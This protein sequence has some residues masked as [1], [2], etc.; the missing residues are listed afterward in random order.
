MKK[1]IILLILLLSTSALFAKNIKA[2]LSYSIFNSPKDGHF[3]ETYL[4]VSSK[5][6][7]FVKNA[8]GKY[9]ATVQV[10]IAF[11]KND[12]IKS[13]SK[14]DLLSPEVSDTIKTDISFLDQQRFL[15]ADG[16]YTLE[17]SIM[18]KNKK[19]ALPFKTTEFLSIYFPTNKVSISGIEF[20][21]SFKKTEI[22]GLLTKSGYDLIP[23]TFNFYPQTINNLT[24]YAEIYNTDKVFAAE[25]KFILNYYI[26]TFETKKMLNDYFKFIKVTSK[27]VIVAFNEFDITN[28]PSGNYNLVVEVRNKDNE[29][30]ANNY[31]FFQRS[32]PSA[33]YKSDDISTLDISNTFVERIGSIDSLRDC[34]KS[35][36][37]ISSQMQ[38]M[39]A[40]TLLKQNEPKTLQQYFLNF[41]YN[42]NSINPEKAWLTYNIEV[43][44]VNKAY[45][46]SI[47]KGYET[48][49][50]RVYLQY[51]PPNDITEVLSDPSSYPY[52]IWHYYILSN[53]RNRKFVF[54]SPDLVTNDYQ[55]L[56]SDAFGELNDPTWQMKLVKRNNSSNDPYQEKSDD[57]Y[58]G[59]ANDYFKNPH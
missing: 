7:E 5:T 15:L 6:V 29:K 17:I 33:H 52:E 18:D 55:L 25:E 19:N 57:Y 8:N 59:K 9:Q 28:L 24:F 36:Y 38:K 4:S 2:Y 37:P 58:G 47:Q 27:N 39:F 34:I 35:T 1:N 54:Y 20:V 30:V 13:F 3:V 12:T 16:D 42:R 10:S 21:K 41:W 56:H 48:D 43:R 51:G 44:K 14:I 32:N 22:T 50:G 26:E 49:R 53:Q 40:E 45:G 46:T 11:K 23:N 31:L